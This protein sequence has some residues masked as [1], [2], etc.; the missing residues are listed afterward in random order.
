MRNAF[1]LLL[2]TLLLSCKSDDP[3][4]GTFELQSAFAGSIGLSLDD[5]TSN[6]P[7]D[8]TLSLRFSTAIDAASTSNGVKLTSNQ[9][10][11]SI[12][13]TLSSDGKSVY[14]ST[15]GPLQ[16]NSTYTLE[17]TSELKSASGA[18][19]TP[20]S[21]SF[22][23]AAGPLEL[24]A[25]SLNS[26]T[27]GNNPRTQNIDPD[28]TI[29]FEFNNAINVQSF[30]SSVA[31]SGKSVTVQ[32]S[33][34]DKT[35]TVTPTS[36]LDFIKKYKLSL[37]N[38]LV[39]AEGQA[40]GGYELEFY[41]K[42][43]PTFKFPEISDDALLTKVQEQTFKYFWD[44]AHPTSGLARERNSSGNTVTIGG[45]G[46]GVMTILVGIERGFITRQ[47]GVDRL[48][49]IV[50]FLKN[51]DRFH[52]VWPHW[53]N[54]N[55]GETIPFSSDDDG[56]DLVETAFMVQG[57]LTIREYLNSGNAQEKAIID[58]ITQLWEEVEWDWF[59][60]GE[61]VLYWHWSPNVGFQKNLKI[62]GWNESLIIYVLAAASPTHPISA[63]VYNQGWARNGAMANGSEYYNI[64]LPLGYE[65]GGPLFFSHYSFLGLDPRNL[66]DQYANYWEQNKA[67][68]LVNRAYSVANP[69]NYVGY[70]EGAWGLTAS[71]NHEGY[72]A[73]SPTNDLGVITPTAA[74]SSFPYTPD[75]SM[76]ALK[77]FY[78]IM[79]DMLWGDYGFY[80][81]FNL[82]ESWVASSYLAIDQGP[83][84][85]MIENHR[86]ALL[87][88]LFMSNNEITDGLDKLG[89]TSY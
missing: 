23:T 26:E 14:V 57:L 69:K 34:N 43:D 40:F 5:V 70:S 50:T 67:H 48:E 63:D 88:D 29:T 64:E 68:T 35:I 82:T 13:T 60:Q 37:S 59:T 39:S 25:V 18:A 31:L 51:A 8:R 78:Y 9:Q 53:M 46:F 76:T 38:R 15:N 6:V 58:N 42:L 7:V 87:W 32:S 75:E 27:V 62:Q 22:S 44:F 10:P 2:A 72:S 19:A 86:T 45:S 77:H 65:F 12:T 61:N 17:I 30:E 56:A 20:V 41:T 11:V 1:L 79:G 85:I 71:D 81:A 74:L 54:G 83:I 3:S 28:L 47:Q 80:D 52:G 66:A 4:G 36:T 89:F 55:T 49:T 84:V 24:I 33:N 73:Q 21:F 16:E